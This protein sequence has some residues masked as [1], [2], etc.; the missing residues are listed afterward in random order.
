MERMGDDSLF[1]RGGMEKLTHKDKEYLIKEAK[2]LNKRG[3][4]IKYNK[5]SELIKAVADARVDEF[6]SRYDKKPE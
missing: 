2:Q 5:L 6:T 4:N 1:K 3:F